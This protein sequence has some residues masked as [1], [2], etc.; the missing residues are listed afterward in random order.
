MAN[1]DMFNGKTN[2]IFVSSSNST[3]IELFIP[4]YS[5][6][7]NIVFNMFAAIYRHRA[8]FYQKQ[9]RADFHIHPKWPFQ[10]PQNQNTLD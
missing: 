8:S 2:H 10:Q 3:T 9:L 7:K 6:Y 4:L 1:V 5:V